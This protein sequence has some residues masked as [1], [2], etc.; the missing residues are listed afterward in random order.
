MNILCIVDGGLVD[1]G[2]FEHMLLI[3]T[4]FD[5]FREIPGIRLNKIP[6]LPKVSAIIT[7]CFVFTSTTPPQL[8]CIL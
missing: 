3:V 2:S 1:R 6:L 5:V 7:W 4:I 8:L